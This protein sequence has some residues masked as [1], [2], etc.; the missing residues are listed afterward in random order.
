MCVKLRMRAREN[1]PVDVATNGSYGRVLL[2]IGLKAY[3]ATENAAGY[4]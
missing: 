4:R 3:C 2:G 1:V